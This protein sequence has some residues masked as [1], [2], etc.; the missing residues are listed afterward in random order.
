MLKERARAVSAGL[1]ALDLALLAGAFPLAH[2]LRDAVAGG[3]L[4]GLYPVGRYV[5]WVALALLVWIASAGLADVYRAYRTRSLAEELGRLGRASAGLALGLAAAGWLANDQQLSRLLLVAWLVVALTL[6]AA[7]RAGLRS[8]AR[9]AR[10]RG[11]NTRTFAV[12]GSGPLARDLRRRFLSRREWGFVF[13]GF[14][15]EDGAVR[16][17]LPGP[18]LGRASEMADLLERHALDLVVVALPRERLADVEAVLAACEEQGTPAKIGLDLFPGRSAPVSVEELDGLPVLSY[19]AAPQEVLELA[20][21][22]AFDVAVSALGLL[23][24]S[25]LVLGVALAVK[26]ESPGPVLFRQ[27]RVGRAGRE[28]TLFKFRSMRAGAEQDRDALLAQNEADGPVFKLRDDPRVTRVGRFL[29]RTSIDEL[30]QLWNVLRGE[31][32]LVGPRPPLPEEVRRY[33]RWQR[34]RLSV[35]PGITCTWQVSGRSDVGF[36]RWMELDLAYIDGWSLWEDV[37]IVLRTIPAV[38]LGRGAR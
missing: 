18:F 34:R 21:K 35:K 5:G 6:L 36:R 3:R 33:E 31:M 16:E 17:G 9:A 32:S 23:V 1:R 37:R 4:S 8:F 14:V 38:L 10:R 15:L 25:P 7:S 28:F 20:A 30:P 24:L 12:V 26:L 22:R 13:A 11:Y 29:R 27:R 2:A 19:A